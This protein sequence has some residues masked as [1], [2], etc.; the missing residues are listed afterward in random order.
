M[1]IKLKKII[2]LS[3]LW[4]LLLI[5]QV[6]ANEAG[7]ESTE[8]IIWG[9]QPLKITLPVGKERIISF[10]SPVKVW[11]PDEIQNNLRAQINGNV[12][13]L[14][15]Q[16][17]FKTQR[18]KIQAIDGSTFYLIDLQAKKKGGSIEPI[19]VIVKK[20]TSQTNDND[21]PSTSAAARQKPPGYILLSRFAAQQLYSPARLLSIPRGVHR[22]PVNRGI[23][24]HLIHGINITAKPI[25]S[26]RYASL[27]VTALELKD[28]TR[29]YI[30]LDPRMIRGRWKAATFQ[31]VRLHP[32]GS[33][34]DTSVLYLISGRPFHEVI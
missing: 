27:Y 23:I 21:T 14:L 32:T 10:Q 3:C 20:A 22:V 24:T 25:A 7:Y 12:V 30:T 2:L 19:E 11:L 28:Q 13:Y 9:K 29:K 17:A 33:E 18:I 15:A 31:H 16:K 6:I 26:W 1:P 8:R 5:Q 34:S 4:P